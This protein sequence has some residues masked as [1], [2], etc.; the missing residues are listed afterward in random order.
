MTADWKPADIVAEGDDYYLLK[1]APGE[2]AKR[3][4]REGDEV[5]IASQELFDGKVVQ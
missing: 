5:I 4:L 2:K 1:A 3:I